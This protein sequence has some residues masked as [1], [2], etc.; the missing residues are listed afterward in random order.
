MY[1]VRLL[2]LTSSKWWPIFYLQLFLLKLNVLFCRCTCR[3]KKQEREIPCLLYPV[4]PMTIP[5]EIVA[6]EHKQ[7]FNINVIRIRAILS[8]E[9]S[10]LCSYALSQSHPH[11]ST[12]LSLISDLGNHY[13]ILHFCNFGIQRMLQKW[14]HRLSIFL[15][16]SS[17]TNSFESYPYCSMFRQLVPFHCQ[18]IVHGLVALLFV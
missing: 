11:P 6:L 18:V 9:G 7:D 16:H 1:S 12:P 8:P 4:S 14:N 3:C 15:S 17:F 5:C 13:S 2:Y 10:L